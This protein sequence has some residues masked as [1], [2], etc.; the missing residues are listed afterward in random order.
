MPSCRKTAQSFSMSEFGPLFDAEYDNLPE[1]LKL[2]YSPKEYAWMTPERRARLIDEE[3][4][5]ETFED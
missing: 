2:I 1:G 4:L 5:P 3:T